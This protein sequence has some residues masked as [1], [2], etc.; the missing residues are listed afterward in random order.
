[1]SVIPSEDQPRN[2]SSPLFGWMRWL[3]RVEDLLFAVSIEKNGNRRSFDC[4]PDPTRQNQR[5]GSSLRALR[6]G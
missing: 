4:A 5:V 1:M 6:S 3:G 2:A